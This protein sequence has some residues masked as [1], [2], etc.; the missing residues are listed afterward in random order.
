[1]ERRTSPVTRLEILRERHQQLDDIVDEMSSREM[2]TPTD[3][4]ELKSLK[5]RRLRLKDAIR[6]LSS[7]SL[8]LPNHFEVK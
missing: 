1:M 6:D 7:D 4:S 5:V 2:L 8:L 3:M